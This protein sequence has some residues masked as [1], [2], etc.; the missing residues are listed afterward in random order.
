M[1]KRASLSAYQNATKC[2]EIMRGKRA[3]SNSTPVEQHQFETGKP[4]LL[5]SAYTLQCQRQE[6]Y[7]RQMI[8]INDAVSIAIVCCLS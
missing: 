4:L 8:E 1:L 6:H 7:T 2:I 3:V 5:K